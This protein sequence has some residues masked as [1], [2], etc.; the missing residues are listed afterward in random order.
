MDR[1]V[2][3]AEDLLQFL[4]DAALLDQLIDRSMRG[5]GGLDVFEEDALRL[6]LGRGG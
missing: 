4:Q 6:M 2:E 5:V 1:Q 3:W